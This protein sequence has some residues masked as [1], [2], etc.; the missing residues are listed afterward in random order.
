MTNPSSEPQKGVPTHLALK[1]LRFLNNLIRLVL[2][3]GHDP[4][5]EVEH[6]NM[7]ACST[8]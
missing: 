2:A 3:A 7:Y 1:P 6:E 8:T 5:M 4:L